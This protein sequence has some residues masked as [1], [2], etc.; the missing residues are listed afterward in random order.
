MRD[1]YL[2]GDEYKLT[3]KQE[4]M[5]INKGKVIDL[6]E[7]NPLF[8][9]LGLDIKGDDTIISSGR[10]ALELFKT[11]IEN[12]VDNGE[13]IV[14]QG[15]DIDDSWYKAVRGYLHDY[16]YTIHVSD[17]SESRNK[18]LKGFKNLSDEL[19]TDWLNFDMYKNVHHIGDI[20]GC[21]DALS[22]LLKEGIKEEDAYIFTGDFLERGDKHIEV[23][24]YLIKISKLPN[25]YFIEGNHEL[26]IINYVRGLKIHSLGFKKDI[27]PLLNKHGYGDGA[28]LKD[29][30]KFCKKLRTHL[31]YTYKGNRVIVT[32]GG[33]SGIPNDIGYLSTK[34][35]VKGTLKRNVDIDTIFDENT[36][37]TKDYQVHGHRNHYNVDIQ[38]GNSINL[39]NS[40]EDGGTLRCATI[41]KSGWMFTEVENRK[42]V[43]K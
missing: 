12:K 4:E 19:K 31:A 15:V 2:I 10:T 20:H 42:P 5:V 37:G 14:L 24:E 6:I 8:V 17:G 40:V 32:H 43:E 26:H 29:L 22:E 3:R 38:T 7:S 39:E 1:I 34:S 23:L 21:Y 35:V 16:G 9:T 33:L 28:K 36:K 41:N 30:R 18:F 11:C 13:T 27:V 25:V